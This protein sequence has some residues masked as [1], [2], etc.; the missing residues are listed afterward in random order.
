LGN[1][2]ADALAENASCDVMLVGSGSI[3]VKKI[4][5]MVTLKDLLTCY[6][7]DEPLS[8]YTIPGSK[9]KKI[10]S[11]IMRKENRNEDGECYQVNSEVKATYSDKTKK[12]KSLKIGGKEVE[13]TRFYT[14]CLQPYHFNKA[15]RNLGISKKDLL[16][17][18]K[19]KVVTT[20]AQEVIEEFLRNNQNIFRKVEGRL[21]YTIR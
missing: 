18:G 4:G 15:K 9:L 2:I 8:R 7:Y 17:S 1:L 20:S 19:T 13:N 12:L 10:F 21:K 11:H 14:I 5:P 6:P 3:R 16:E